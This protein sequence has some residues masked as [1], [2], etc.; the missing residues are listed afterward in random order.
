M[1]TITRTRLCVAK[2]TTFLTQVSFKSLTSVSRHIKIGE[3]DLKYFGK[4]LDCYFISTLHEI[5][6]NAS[7]EQYCGTIFQFIFDKLSINFE[8][9][10]QLL[11]SRHVQIASHCDQLNVLHF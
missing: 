3:Y 2:N 7:S 9:F 5:L 6:I 4:L 8:Q 10:K 11:N 1:L